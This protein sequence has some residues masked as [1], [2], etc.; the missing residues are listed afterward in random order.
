VVVRVG[1]LAGRAYLF[2]VRTRER[3]R[4]ARARIPDRVEPAR[5]SLA[6]IKLQRTLFLGLAILI[7]AGLA[8]DE[9]IRLAWEPTL[10][11]LEVGQWLRSHLSK[12]SPETLRNLLAAAAGGT[13]TIL[14]LVISI[15]LIVWQATADRYRSSSIVGFLLRERLGAA[16]VRLLA[17]G[18]AYSLWV[19][20]LLEVLEFRP[21]AS[22]AFALVL[23][24]AAVL[25]LISYRHLGLLGYLPRNIARSLRQEI[26]REVLR[27]QRK[28]AGRSVEN[29]SRQVVE[30]DLQIFRDLVV[31]LRNDSEF[32]DVGACLEELGAALSTF[33]QLKHRFPR[34]SLFFV[35]RKERLGPSGYA[36]EEAIGA[37]GLMSPTT[38][39]P[40]HLWF[41]RRVLDVVDLA[42]TQPLLENTDVA[43]ALIRA[44][45][46]ALQYAWYNED[47]DAV[48]LILTRIEQAASHPELRSSPGVAEELLT[49]PWVM[50]ELA[51][52]G[53][54]V[55]AGAIVHR[56][57]WRGEARIRDLPWK[58]QE[59][60][61]ELARRI[62][63]ELVVTGSVMTPDAEMIR[64]VEKLRQPRLSE[65]QRRLVDRAIGLARSELKS[66]VS[67]KSDEATA[68]AQMTIRTLLRIV[69]HGLQLPDLAGLA[70][71]IVATTGLADQQQVEDLQGASGRAARVLAEHQRW[72]AAHELLHVSE[73]AGLLARS[74]AG[75]QQR[76]LRLFFEGLFTAA[77]VYGWGEF[78]RRSDHV[79]AV[80][81]YLQ[82]PYA[83]LD[84]L[85]DA[86]AKHQLSG[87]MFPTVVHYQWVQ[88]LSMAA[89]ALEDRPVFDGGIGYSLE[90]DHPS[91]LFAKSHL[92]GVGP[93]ECLE[94]LIAAVVDDRTAAREAL[95]NVIASLINKRGEP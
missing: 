4:I 92:Q 5:T 16:V 28:S 52:A 2:T 6:L 35:H 26:V 68:I 1:R 75:E 90:K 11:R 93:M 58:A 74:Q 62:R 60:A 15:S 9:L 48:D 78:H 17:L 95:L 73:V 50:V 79:R 44:W 8:A 86:A 72:A 18:F 88:P 76:Q 89:H 65:L 3:G 39:V 27:A 21:Y 14:G 71:E 56:K 42:V 32:L 13:A 54:A 24:T 19:L 64:E 33:V 37:Q 59:D 40:D 77:I 45:A 61:R 81:P 70:R 12:P 43:S 31:R 10:G 57:P 29:Y 22:A 55:D 63:T 83:D 84:L 23:S 69:H 87:L 41:E 25:S 46:T 53:F 67:E 7:V 82:Q 94:H 80:G 30:A 85:A 51:G 34:S 91:D 47:P 49:V 38:D 66:A 36:I 20:A